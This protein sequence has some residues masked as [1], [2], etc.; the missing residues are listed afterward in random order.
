MPTISKRVRT[1]LHRAVLLYACRPAQ[2]PRTKGIAGSNIHRE[3]RL[4]V[5]AVP[6]HDDSTATRAS[7][8]LA[9]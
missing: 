2:I 5:G 1:P 9:K 7:S 8:E 3:W 4:D 6:E